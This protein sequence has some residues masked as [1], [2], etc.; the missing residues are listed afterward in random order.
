M[1]Q[2]NPF[3]ILPNTHLG[4]PKLVKTFKSY[5]FSDE[6][7]EAQ[8]TDSPTLKQQIQG[9]R[10]KVISWI[11]AFLL[12][13]LTYRVFWLQLVKGSEYRRSAENN[14]IRISSIPPVRG[15]IYDKNGKSLVENIAEF[16]FGVIPA[17]L[18]NESDARAQQLSAFAET[19]GIPVAEFEKVLVEKKANSTEFAVVKEHLDYAQ[20]MKLKILFKNEPAVKVEIMPRR[21]YL[22]GEAFSQI[23]G[24]TGKIS[25]TEWDDIKNSEDNDYQMN[26]VIGKTG[27]EAVYERQMRGISGKASIEVNA[28]RREQKVLA[29]EEAV[30]GQNLVLHLDSELQ[31]LLYKKAN[32]TVKALRT[33]GAAVVALDP[34]TGGVLAMVNAPSYDN[35]DFVSGISSSLY[36]QL[37]T[38]SHKPLFPRAVAGEYPSGSTIK[39]L[40]AVAALDQG[41]VTP[42]TTVLST[43]GIKIDK[44]FFPDWR[45]GGHGVTNIYKAIADSVNTYFY[46]IGGGTENFDG[47]GIDRMTQ[48]A[49][50]FGLGGQTGLDLPGERPGFLPSKAWKEQ[51]KGE[52][53][54]IGDTYHFAI[55]Q[56]DLLVTPVQMALMTATIANGGTVFKP[57]L[58]AAF[59]DSAKKISKTIEPEI[60]RKQIAKP[61]A[62]QVVRDAMRQAV[63]SGSASRLQSISQPVCGKTGTAQFGNQNKTHAWF[64]GFAPCTNAS[65]AIAVIVEGGGEGHAA[66]LPIAESG[67]K[68]WLKK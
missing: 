65:I 28:E 19:A 12:C 15:V 17:D 41:I 50:T 24:Y 3:E 54:Y 37:I 36:E 2:L 55:G 42:Q 57:H 66:A 20:A 40:F 29:A 1:V 18:K 67:F 59:Q 23:L 53:W 44:W 56:G 48:Y 25:E 26:E 43:G 5:E 7:L 11:F 47:L 32:A 16:S 52:A 60:I 63:T 58:V 45:P 34:Q 27:L 14:R 31:K 4:K 9:K 6:T 8:R 33:T 46:T 68:Y 61:E 64:I 13:L 38:D 62:F 39:P 51:T 21:H 22:G 30:P 35:N 10:L 49:R